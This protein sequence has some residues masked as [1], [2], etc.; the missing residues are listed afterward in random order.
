MAETRTLYNTLTTDRTDITRGTDSYFT[1]TANCVNA[2]GEMIVTYAVFVRTPSMFAPKMAVD[3]LKEVARKDD[4][5]VEFESEFKPGDIVPAGQAQ[6][7]IRGPFSK[8]AECE[9]FFLQKIGAVSVAALNAYKACKEL[10]NI[11]FIAMGARHCV[12]TEMQEMMDYAA[13]VGGIAAQRD[14]DAKGFINGASDATAHFFGQEKGTGTTPHALIGYYGGSTVRAAEAFRRICPD[15]PFT[16]LVDF[17]GK[18]ITDAIEVARRFPKEAENGTLAFRLD[19]HGGRYL[20]GL[21]HEQSIEVLN[22]HA[23]QTMIEEWNEKELKILY[24]RGVSVAS[25]WKFKNAMVEAGL[26]NVGIIGSSGFNAQKCRIM[27]FANAPLSGVGTGSYIPADFHRTY[28]T[29]DVF[30]YDG[31]TSIKVGREYLAERYATAKSQQTLK[32]L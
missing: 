9:T 14:F 12:G 7:Y 20:E 23:P 1:N 10:K 11:P 6:L 17:E 31:Q 3:W 22:R 32:P 24:G 13:S 26:P 27:S 29:A 25:I 4:F 8:L 30:D 21:D 16:I 28:A 15:K 2:D 18:E 19:T 5:E